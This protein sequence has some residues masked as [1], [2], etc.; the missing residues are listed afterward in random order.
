M[1]L[2]D[3]VVESKRKKAIGVQLL[4]QGNIPKALKTFENIVSFYSSGQIN[5]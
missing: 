2:E 4:K 3:K 5:Q 1:E